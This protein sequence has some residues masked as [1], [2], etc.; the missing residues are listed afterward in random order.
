MGG[1]CFEGGGFGHFPA[2]GGVRQKYR[3]GTMGFGRQVG[4]VLESSCFERK[5]NFVVLISARTK[6]GLVDK[7]I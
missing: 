2:L 7:Y 3:D 6:V 4:A 5:G 1:A